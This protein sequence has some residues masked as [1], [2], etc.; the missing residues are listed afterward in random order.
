MTTILF[1]ASRGGASELHSTIDKA[2]RDK[3]GFNL[4]SVNNSTDVQQI[5]LYSIMVQ[6]DAIIE[7]FRIAMAQIEKRIGELFK[8]SQM[9]YTIFAKMVS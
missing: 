3:F 1:L 5:R 6:I 8:S 7:R 2:M 9:F 4:E